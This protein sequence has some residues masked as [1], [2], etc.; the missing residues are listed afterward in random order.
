MQMNGMN[1]ISDVEFTFSLWST[2]GD[3]PTEWYENDSAGLSRLI[4]TL[5][6]RRLSVRDQITAFRR[7][8]RD[9]FPNWQS[10]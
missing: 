1:I 9:P 8:S 5:H 7:S 10:G 4:E 2:A 3:V 6:R